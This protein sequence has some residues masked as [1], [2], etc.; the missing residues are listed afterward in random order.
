M[1]SYHLIHSAVDAISPSRPSFAGGE[2]KTK[3]IL[4]VDGSLLDAR[5]R[6][7]GL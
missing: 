1:K 4:D 3:E 6:N 2:R 7:A 5:G